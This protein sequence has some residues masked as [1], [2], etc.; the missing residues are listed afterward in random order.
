MVFYAIFNNL[1]ISQWPVQLSVTSLRSFY[2]HFAQCFFSN[3]LAA[4]P[5]KPS[6]KQLTGERRMNP[7]AMTTISPLKI[8][9]IRGSNLRPTFRKSS[10]LPSVL[11]YN[12]ILVKREEKKKVHV[13]NGIHKLLGL[14]TFLQD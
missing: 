12:N 5:Q 10:T 14:Y 9:P 3:P 13:R 2:Q 11:H 6:S 7:V 4:F 1:F 8:W